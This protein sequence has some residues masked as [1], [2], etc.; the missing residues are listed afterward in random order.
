MKV[1]LIIAILLCKAQISFSQTEKRLNGNV[2]SD[3]FSL[4]GIEIIN[5]NTQ[6]VA[7]T[8]T[9]G[10]FSIAV[11]EK[12]KLVFFGIDYLTQSIYL[13]PEIL[14]RNNLEVVLVKKPIE[15]DEVVIEQKANIWNE[16]YL[17]QIVDKPYFDDRMSSP[18]NQYVYDGQ[19]LGVDLIGIGKKVKRLL[20]S[21]SKEKKE[22]PKIPFKDYV[23]ANF[24]QNFFLETLHLKPEEIHLFLEYCEADPNSTTIIGTSNFDALDFLVAKSVSFRKSSAIP[25]SAKP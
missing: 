2:K 7:I 24:N 13:N 17:Q 16:S 6:Q 21:K 3:N 11:S 19:T 9:N 23:T 15:I 12:D 25:E 1:K 14:S 20:K 10:N 18:K 4:K 8:D 22:G 5:E